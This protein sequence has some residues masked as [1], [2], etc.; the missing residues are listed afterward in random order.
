MWWRN[1]WTNG[2]WEQATQHLGRTASSA[3]RVTYIDSNS[4]GRVSPSDAI[5]VWVSSCSGELPVGLG[6]N[7][8]AFAYQQ[9][10]TLTSGYTFT[11]I[12]EGPGAVP[13]VVLGLVAAVIIAVPV[14]LVLV[15]RRRRSR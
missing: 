5:Q 11:C 4:D 13:P 14:G 12:P 9:N 2:T 10:I 8:T 3:E 1:V 7:A 6:T 15:L